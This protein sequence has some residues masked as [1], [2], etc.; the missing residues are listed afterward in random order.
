MNREFIITYSLLAKDP[1]DP[2]EAYTL[3]FRTMK[4]FSDW[5]N[6]DPCSIIIFSIVEV[7]GDPRYDKYF[8]EFMEK[9]QKK[10]D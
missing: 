9:Y 5:F 1:K 2:Y 3:T 10:K 6:K 7:E 8:T 4:H